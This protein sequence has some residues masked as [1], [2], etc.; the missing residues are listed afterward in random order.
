MALTLLFGVRACVILFE[1]YK[2]IQYVH[3]ILV[4]VQSHF[5]LYLTVDDLIFI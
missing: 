4:L 2:Q 3:Y 5:N 1:A